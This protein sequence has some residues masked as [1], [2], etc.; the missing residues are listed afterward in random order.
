MRSFQDGTGQAVPLLEAAVKADPGFAAAYLRLWVMV[1]CAAQRSWF[2]NDPSEHATEYHQRII[3]S[4]A[5]LSPRDQELLDGVENPGDESNRESNAKLDAYLVRYPDDDVAWVARLDGRLDTARR[6]AAARPTLVPALAKLADDMMAYFETDGAA[7]VLAQ[8]LAISPRAVDCISARAVL[9]DMKGECAAA[10]ADL[11]RWLSLQPDSRRAR[12][13]FAALLAAQHAPLESVR[14]A[15]GADA[16]GP[17]WETIVDAL[18]PM[19]EGDFAEVQRIAADASARVS[20][21][22][23]ESEH[24]GPASTLVQALTE[25]GD[26]AGAGRVAVD[27][28]AHRAGWR[29]LRTIV[30]APMIR[31]AARAGRLGASEAS[32]PLEDAFGVLKPIS[33]GS[34]WLYAYADGVETP[35]EASAAVAKLDALGIALPRTEQSMVGRVLFLAGRHE[36]ARPPLQADVTVC[37]NSLLFARNWVRDHLYLGELD[38]QAGNKPSACAHY[39]VV[40][41]RWGHAKP[42]SVTADEARAHATKLGCAL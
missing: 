3:A 7:D 25:A 35:A 19:F 8:C 30:P 17:A 36:D 23:A 26:A 39:A 5:A 32:R 9:H 13:T 42:R 37:S 6:A 40:L 21:S 34:A 27:Y 15:L 1:S 14:G 33:P 20:P 18:V 10:E 12:P 16:A 4:Q 38:E 22:A 2:G 31:A 41:S 24:Y 28:L 29:K 11:R